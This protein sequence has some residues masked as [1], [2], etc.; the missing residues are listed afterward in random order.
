MALDDRLDLRQLVAR[1]DGKTGRIGSN[2]LVLA[3]RHR[4]LLGAAGGTALADEADGRI[5]LRV[6]LLGHLGDALVDFPIQRLVSCQ[7][8]LSFPHRAIVCRNGLPSQPV[9]ET[10]S[11]RPP[12]GR[13][14]QQREPAQSRWSR[15][16]F[17]AAEAGLPTAS[18]GGRTRT[19]NPRFWRP[20]LCQLSYAPRGCASD[21]IRGP[22][23]I[24]LWLLL[25][26][27][28][29]SA[30]SFSCWR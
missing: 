20:V 27:G 8:L 24:S 10:W 18:R 7:T 21:C 14:S 25:H 13:R 29:H 5:G 4:N 6:E 30:R 26:S 15:H 1:N 19:C 9:F 2:R 12:G 22:S 3:Q 11:P 23:S 16:G 17:G 28:A